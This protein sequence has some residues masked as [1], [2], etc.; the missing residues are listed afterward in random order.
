M[1]PDKLVSRIKAVL[2]GDTGHFEIQSLAHEYTGLLMH[3]RDRIDQ[4][5]TLIR[6]GNDYAALQVAE[7]AP[8]LL[9]TAAKLAFAESNEWLALCRAR[10]LPWPPPLDPREVDLVGSLYGRQISESHPLYRDYR[11]A[12]RERDELRA[13]AILASIIRINPDDRNARHE[14]VRLGE[15]ISESHLRKLETL[16]DAGDLDA[17]FALAETL[18]NLRLPALAHAPALERTHA[19]REQR[20][21]DTALAEALE[22]LRQVALLRQTGDWRETIPLLGHIRSLE[23]HHRLEFDADTLAD[24]AD[25]EAWAGHYQDALDRLHERENQI[26]RVNE[27]LRAAA[28]GNPRAPAAPALRRL[29][30][31]LAAAE[32]LDASADA[33]AAEIP[34]L[35]ETHAPRNLRPDPALLDAARARR[36]TLQSRA[37]RR[38]LLFAAASLAA[39]VAVAATALTLRHRS[40][41][42]LNRAQNALRMNSAP[43]ENNLLAAENLLRSLDPA[44]DS[45][46]DFAAAKKKLAEWTATKRAATDALLSELDT[47]A[48][49]ADETPPDTLGKALA[50][51]PAL[52]ETAAALPFDARVPAT[53]KLAAAETRAAALREKL[54]AAVLP[55]LARETDDLENRFA[56]A[57]ALPSTVQRLAELTALRAR[58]EDFAQTHAQHTFLLSPEEHRRWRELSTAVAAAHTHCQREAGADN[59]LANTGTLDE[60]FSALKTLAAPPAQDAAETPPPPPFPALALLLSNEAALRNPAAHILHPGIYRLWRHAALTPTDAQPFLPAAT[61]PGEAADAADLVKN[62]DLE[63]IYHNT[64]RIFPQRANTAFSPVHTLGTPLFERRPMGGGY[65]LIYTATVYQED[66]S[67][68]KRTYTLRQYDHLSAQ[69]ASLSNPTFTPE[70]AFLRQFSRFYDTPSARIAEPILAT[71]DRVRAAPRVSPLLKA[72]LQQRLHKIA[73]ARPDEWGVSFSPTARHA[74]QTLLQLAPGALT[75]SDWLSP[76]RWNDRLPPLARFY[77]SPLPSYYGEAVA[78]L[79][80]FQHLANPGFRYAGH[81]TSEKKLRP[82]PRQNITGNLVGLTPDGALLRVPAA[83][84]LLPAAENTPENAPLALREPVPFAPHS[85]VLM[86]PV[87]PSEAAALVK[88]PPAAIVP[89]GGWNKFIFQPPPAHGN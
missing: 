63:N 21:R 65:E 2:N 55:V 10:D 24:L 46:P 17:A 50:R 25:L 29:S 70:S 77:E 28:E 8:P 41:D 15:K 35:A 47:L 68:E 13:I 42:K 58:A 43:G 79:R 18:E 83:D 64:L 81:I 34:P 86:L 37:R 54:A 49:L 73:A 67:T 72:A 59:A 56:A 20:E 69:G 7:S 66:G 60:Y 39:L 61:L 51:L 11:Q 89:A 5:V 1:H 84:L 3:I 33:A 36:D 88:F 19:L 32:T 85:P 74:A 87:Q 53:A 26:H 76:S 27:E 78:W 12:I 23:H 62:K 82:A 38:K 80:V 44:W 14:F 45:D 4:C 6:A 71:I 52:K 9:D 31:V 48:A 40:L 16:L 57:R 22:N 75:P 30:R